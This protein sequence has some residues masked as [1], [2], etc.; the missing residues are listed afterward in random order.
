MAKKTKATYAPGELRQTRDNLGQLNDKEAMRMAQVLGGEVGYERTT[1]EEE[2]LQQKSRKETVELFVKGRPGP[3]KRRVEV[4]GLDEGETDKYA[5]SQPGPYDKKMNPGDD[6]S[7]LL[8]PSYLERAKM[9]RFAALPE[10]EIKSVVQAMFSAFSLFSEPPDYVNPLFVTKRL[11]EYYKRIEQ[12]VIS[13]RT[14][15]PRNNAKRSERLKKVSPFFYSVLDTIRYWDIEHITSEMSKIQSHPRSAKIS[16]FAD[17]L[18]VIYRPLFILEQLNMET[19]IKGA[20]K[21]LY[22]ILYIE[23]PI[24]SKEKSQEL[25]R[26]AL[27]S[28]TVIRK[29]VHFLLYPLLMKLISDRWFS[30]ER[31]FIE[32]RN[33]FMALLKVTGLD[34]INIPTEEEVGSGDMEAVLRED[35]KNEATLVEPEEGDVSKVQE[36]KAREAAEQEA[37][38]KALERGLSTLELLFPKA[39]WERLASFPDLYPYFA[40]LFD[41]KKGYELIAPTDPLQQV[42]MLMHILREF[43]VALRSVSFGIIIEADG[44]TVQVED[45]LANVMNNWQNYINAGFNKDYLPRLIECCEILEQSVDA[46]NSAFT[47]R[48]ISELN[49]AKRFYFFPYHKFGT[50]GPPPIQK[51]D[52]TPIYTEIRKFRRYLSAVAAGIEHGNNQGGAEAQVLCDGID[53]P[54]EPYKFAISNP[55][56]MRLDLLLSPKKRNNATLVLFS[57]SV[58][59]VLDHLVNNE[60]SW[61]YEGRSGPLFRSVHNEG[62]KPL[63]GVDTK[64]DADAI[65][66]QTLKQRQQ[67]REQKKANT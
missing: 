50:I 25:I 13:T 20:Y 43:F 58:A 17:I 44:N 37:E 38:R 49:W 66:R 31:F 63:F 35:I 53:N 51:Q 33:R 57:L 45:Y 62:I 19:H 21:L 47:R 60:S 30:Y 40:N 5:V 14:L 2:S 16:E 67:E 3:P 11:G 23:N 9:D 18:R 56:S 54:W 24:D 1:S 7:V 27:S 41:L 42:V 55:I 12:L 36:Q 65:F 46:R 22:K 48:I 64:L 34:R 39:G 32:R 8:R 15:F 10:F 4:I 28:F 29:E 6:P 59:T 52:T 61:A 26:T